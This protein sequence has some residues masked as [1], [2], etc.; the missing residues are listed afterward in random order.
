MTRRVLDEN[1]QY[2]EMMTIGGRLMDFYVDREEGDII[3]SD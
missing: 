2:G 1:G 3:I